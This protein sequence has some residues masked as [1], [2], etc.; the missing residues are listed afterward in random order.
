[1]VVRAEYVSFTVV[2][3][4]VYVPNVGADRVHFLTELNVVLSVGLKRFYFWKEEVLTAGNDQ[5]DRNHL[6]PHGASRHTI[7]QLTETQCT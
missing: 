1:M 2:F 6:E 3:V 4:N 5:V 7:Q